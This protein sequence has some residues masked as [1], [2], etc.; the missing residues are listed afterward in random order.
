MDVPQIEIRPVRADDA[1]A[2]R[3]LRL[4]ALKQEPASF[5]ASYEEAARTDPEAFAASIPAPGGPNVLFGLYLDGAL[6]GA[7]GFVV[8]AGLKRRHKGL[9]WGVYVRPAWRGRGFAKALVERV[10]GHARGQVAL[11]QASVTV[12]ADA[13]RRAYL[14]LGFRPYGLEP[15][16]LRVDGVDFDEELLWIDFRS[17]ALP[18]PGISDRRA[19]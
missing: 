19:P 10:I 1:E 12:G 4:Q 13:A 16:A 8:Q 18:A 15:A 7:A 11:L 14:A 17:A 6:E 3:A 5:A 9:L 2:W